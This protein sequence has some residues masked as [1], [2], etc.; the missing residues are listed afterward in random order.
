[1]SIASIRY[2]QLLR[3]AH[4]GIKLG[5]PQQ[6]YTHLDM[7][8]ITAADMKFQGRSGGGKWV[9]LLL[10]C[11]WLWSEENHHMC[12][13]QLLHSHTQISRLCGNSNT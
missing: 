4:W 6:H 1:M 12:W 3:D 5:V 10:L 9:L 13:Q 7:R 2:Q 8:R 11:L